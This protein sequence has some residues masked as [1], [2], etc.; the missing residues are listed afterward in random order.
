MAT[1][2]TTLTMIKMTLQAQ[3]YARKTNIHVFSSVTAIFFVVGSSV[4]FI[5]NSTNQKLAENTIEGLSYL[6][7]SYT[8]KKN[9]FDIHI[10]SSIIYFGFVC[11]FIA[12]SL[13]SRPPS[14]FSSELSTVLFYLFSFLSHSC[15]NFLA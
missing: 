7:F 13:V 11:L 8:Q 2:K 5:Y 4:L 3:K 12:V 15:L 1:T 10:G 14:P 6:F 9:S